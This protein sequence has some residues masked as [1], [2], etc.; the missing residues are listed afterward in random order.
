MI[1]QDHL[2]VFDLTLKT[3]SPLF[4]G[5]GRKI[6]KREYIYSPN[7]GC[8]KI[9]NM[10]LFFD[11]ML[12]HDLVRQFEKFMLSSNSS[13]LD[14]WTRDCHLAEDWLEHP[15]LMGDKPLIQY[16]LAVT[17][18]VAGYNG[19]KE[20]HQFQ[21][22][23][24]GRAYIPGSS[25]KGA[26]RTAW[27]V[28]LLLHET[29]VSD[30]KRTLEAFE[31]NH[32]YVFPEGSYANKLRSGAATD[33]ILGSIFRG[34]QVSDSTPIDNDK[35]ILTGRTLIS[36]L[37]AA[38]VEHFDG[39]AKDLPLYQECV[40]PGETIRFRLTL[41]QSILNRHGR[42]QPLLS[43]DLSVALPAEPPRR[44]HSGHPAP[45][46]WR[47][48]RLSLQNG[49]LPLPEGR[50][51]R[52]PEMDPAHSADPARSSRGR[53]WP[54][55]FAAPCAVHHLCRQTLPGRVL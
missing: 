4:V 10:E 18:D 23:A 44:K 1:Q 31:V 30:K 52:R 7:Q 54:W 19:T 16:R 25:L 3:Q 14:F 42:V 53:H 29:P 17:E 48:H 40:R 21:R 22:D 32:D 36:P 39:D 33:D 8:V 46:S 35:L 5:S 28:H 43:G 34:I 13:L 50:L 55:R 41:D 2:Q 27:L 38:R 9:L 47:R 37:S 51:C 11:Y 26:L 45:H 20:I 6:G 15:K 49:R 12:R 24:Y